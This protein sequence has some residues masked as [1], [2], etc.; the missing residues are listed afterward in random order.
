VKIIS[1]GQNGA[2]RAGLEAAVTLGLDVGGTVP[3]GRRT[4]GEPLTYEEMAMFHLVENRYSGYPKRTRQ[5]V[6]DS[7]GTVLFGDMKSPGCRLTIRLCREHAKAYIVN[8]TA[9]TLKEWVR[10]NG[11]RALNVAGNSEKRNPGIGQYV[12][13]LLVEAFGRGEN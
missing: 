7:D 6:I 1:G 13:Q 11:I 12:F 9:N 10:E 4:D 5:N 2:D 3:L 8:P